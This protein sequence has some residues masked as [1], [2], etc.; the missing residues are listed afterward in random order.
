MDAKGARTSGTPFVSFFTS[1]QTLAPAR[2]AGVKEA[3]HVASADLAWRY[4]S[5]RTDGLRRPTDGQEP[6]IAMTGGPGGG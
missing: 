3:R 5:R 1:R 6:P 2:D 4:F